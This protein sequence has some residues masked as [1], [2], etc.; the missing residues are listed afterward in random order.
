VDGEC[1]SKPVPPRGEKFFSICL[2]ILEILFCFVFFLFPKEWEHIPLQ[3]AVP[4]AIYQ[5]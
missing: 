2:G 5:T 4:S 1:G 3:N